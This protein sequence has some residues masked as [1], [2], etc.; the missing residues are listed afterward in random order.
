MT[1]AELLAERAAA[2]VEAV[3]ICNLYFGDEGENARW[4]RLQAAVAAYDAT[5]AAEAPGAPADA[6]AEC[7]RRYTEL[8]SLCWDLQQERDAAMASLAECRRE[9]AKRDN[10]IDEYRAATREELK[11]RDALIDAARAREARLVEALREVALH[12]TD[13]PAA[14]GEGN[15]GDG[16][17]RRIAGNCISIA[18]R[19]LPS[20]D[21]PLPSPATPSSA[22]LERAK[23]VE[24][25]EAV[26]ELLEQR[27]ADNAIEAHDDLCAKG[28][29]GHPRACHTPRCHVDGR[30]NCGRFMDSAAPT[31]GA[32]EELFVVRLI[33][34]GRDDGT[35]GPVPWKE[36]DAFRESYMAGHGVGNGGHRRSAVI[37]RSAAPGKDR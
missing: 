23:I 21:G 14:M 24:R 17:F 30:C 33:C 3:R 27:G 8:S 18:A 20:D 31:T 35:Y 36:A 11:A 22:E 9:L 5:P 7:K 29:C 10:Y 6:H 16:W 34:C 2:V 26:I 19:A 15:D 13:R 4:K 25:E 12:G 28:G 37:E 32:G 1:A